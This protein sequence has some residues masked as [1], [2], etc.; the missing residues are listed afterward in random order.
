M[1]ARSYYSTVIQ[2]LRKSVQH[3]IHKIDGKKYVFLP[4][5]AGREIEKQA[6]ITKDNAFLSAEELTGH[7]INSQISAYEVFSVSAGTSD[8]PGT[9]HN[10]SVEPATHINGLLQYYAQKNGSIGASRRKSLGASRSL[11]RTTL[12]RRR[13]LKSR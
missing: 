13:L 5:P 7:P 6:R 1:D 4:T 10:V 11:R 12:R 8:T 9:L 2:P 3:T